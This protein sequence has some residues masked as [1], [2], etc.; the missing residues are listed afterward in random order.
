VQN[1]RNANIFKERQLGAPCEPRENAITFRAAAIRNIPLGGRKAEPN[2]EKT[3]SRRRKIIE[4]LTGTT[5]KM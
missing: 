2:L 1:S 4:M 5:N 3:V